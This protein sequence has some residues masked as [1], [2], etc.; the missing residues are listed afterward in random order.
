M[1]S[2]KRRKQRRSVQKHWKKR[3]Q[4][5]KKKDPKKD[6]KQQ[7]N[8]KNGSRNQKTNPPVF[9]KSEKIS[10][11]PGGAFITESGVDV[12]GRHYKGAI[13][14]AGLKRIDVDGEQEVPKPEP[15]SKLVG[16]SSSIC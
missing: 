9:A 8:Q 3:K 10:G 12:T 6:D 7:G 11:K 2:G 15:R 4:A 13:I 14:S 5:S 1:P 16:G